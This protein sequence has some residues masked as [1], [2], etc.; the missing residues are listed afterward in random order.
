MI[1]Q[2]SEIN[3]LKLTSQNIIMRSVFTILLISTILQGAFCQSSSVLAT[4]LAA[5]VCGTEASSQYFVL[6]AV[7]GSVKFAGAPPYVQVACPASDAY[8][9][10][11]TSYSANA[12]AVTTLNTKTGSCGSTVFYDVSASPYNGTAPVGSRI[13]VFVSAAPNVSSLPSN[14]FANLCGQGPILVAFGNYTGSTPFF[15][16]NQPYNSSCGAYALVT[17]KINGVSQKIQYNPALMNAS[18][19]AFVAVDEGNNVRY[20]VA[21]NC[22]CPEL[23]C[24]NPP[25]INFSGDLTICEKEKTT[26]TA[27]AGSGYQ[28]TWSTGATSASVEVGPAVTSS[29]FVTITSTTAAQCQSS[30]KVTVDVFNFPATQLYTEGTGGGKACYQEKLFLR[31]N[32]NLQGATL[33]SYQWKAISTSTIIERDESIIINERSAGTYQCVLQ[34]SNGCIDRPSVEASYSVQMPLRICTNSPVC[35]GQNATLE[36]S[37]PGSMYNWT[38]PNGYSA[39]GPSQV[40]P[41]PTAGNYQISLKDENGCTLSGTS[42]IILKSCGPLGLNAMLASTQTTCGNNNGLITVT[43]LHGTPPYTYN[44]SHLNSAN[45]PATVSNL[46]PATYTVTISDTAG[47]T[48]T[49]N[50]TIVPSDGVIIT[51]TSINASCNAN[52]GSITQSASGTNAPYVY[53]WNHITGTDNPQNLTGLASGTYTVIVT[54]AN[55]CTKIKT[56]VLTNT[57]NITLTP[58]ITS[59]GCGTVANTG[60]ITITISGGTSPY[61]YNWSNGATTQNIANVPANKYWITITDVNGCT[62]VMDISVPNFDPVFSASISNPPGANNGAITL[63]VSSGASPY[64]FDWAHIAG[65]NN[66]QNISSLANGNYSVT[67]TGSNQC[68]SSNTYTIIPNDINPLIGGDDDSDALVESSDSVTITVGTSLIDAVKIVKIYPN[69]AS[70]A[71]TIAI[72]QVIGKCDIEIYDALSRQILRTQAIGD[73]VIDTQ[74]WS[75]GLYFVFIKPQ[76]DKLAN[77]IWKSIVISK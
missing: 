7:S 2:A 44:W 58:A 67:V 66:A 37:Q 25:V 41:N 6:S 15:F 54:A 52:N 74:I 70:T 49:A 38:G 34:Y 46:A 27:N 69:P 20:G 29:Y 61:S 31:K 11:I 51:G 35:V 55:G 43:A 4:W 53:D 71:F 73:T 76:S 50:S 17:F 47:N 19:G 57:G 65:T 72:P 8:T 26:I 28:Y 14:A 63:T 68:T 22:S 64:T 45:Q 30:A 3:S 13:M 59:A 12:T 1:K 24:P 21:S 39:S 36:V 40:I 5:D 32:I 62:K 33:S 18:D 56:Y 42:T 75:S 23:S 48:H 77:P 10:S 16:N 60:A 9:K